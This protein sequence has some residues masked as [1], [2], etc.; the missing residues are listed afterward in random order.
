M[1]S[2]PIAACVLGLKLTWEDIDWQRKQIIVCGHPETGTRNSELRRIPILPDMKVL[3]R[4]LKEKLVAGILRPGAAES[5]GDYAIWHSARQDARFHGRRGCLP[6][7]RSP[8][9][10]TAI[11]LTP[12]GVNLILLP[13]SGLRAGPSEHRENIVGFISGFGSGCMRSWDARARNERL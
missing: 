9:R 13:V 6:L 8:I 12:S 4:R 10:R 3:L 2:L 7:R 1:N 5:R 11:S